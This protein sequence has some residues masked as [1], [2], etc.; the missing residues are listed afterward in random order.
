[1][2]C[3]RAT[4]DRRPY[5]IAGATV[6]GRAR[7]PAG[8]CARPGG[9][10]RH[11]TA[12][13]VATTMVERE[14]GLSSAE[15]AARL[16]AHGRNQLQVQRRLAVR[17]HRRRLAR[18]GAAAGRA[19]RGLSGVTAVYVGAAEPTKTWFYRHEAA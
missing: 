13:A 10:A 14:R 18:P 4:G 9:P 16:R 3:A 6:T 11:G 19:G 1:M 17:L 7:G 2:R 12:L 15:A 8:G 5:A